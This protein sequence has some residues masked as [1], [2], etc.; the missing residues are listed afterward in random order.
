VVS[1]KGVALAGANV[2]GTGATCT[3]S[4][5]NGAYTCSLALGWGGSIAATLT[6]Y[7]FAPAQ[8]TYSTLTA[9]LVNQNFAATLVTQK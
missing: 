4:G 3:N 1:S 7:T 6:G 9:S 2:A 5:T 8:I